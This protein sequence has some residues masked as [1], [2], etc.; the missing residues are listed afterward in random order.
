MRLG[1]I[2]ET[3]YHGAY[4]ELSQIGPGGQENHKS[5]TRLKARM[6]SLQGRVNPGCF[7]RVGNH[8]C[9]LGIRS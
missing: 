3:G 1:C 5:S 9:K 2:L 4:G 8:D 7:R 6:G